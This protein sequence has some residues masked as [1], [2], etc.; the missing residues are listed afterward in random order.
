MSL[1]QEIY[2]EYS[3]EELPA[4]LDSLSPEELAEMERILVADEQDEIVKRCSE[5]VVAHDRGPMYFLRE[6]TKT[7]NFHYDKQG[8]PPKAPFPYK[9]HGVDFPHKTSGQPDWY[10][11]RAIEHKEWDYLD[12]VMNGLLGSYDL[13]KPIYIP[14]SREMLTSWL[15]VGYIFWMCQFFH[16]VEV[17][18]QSEKDDKAKGLITYANCLYTN[19]PDWMKKRFPLVR[20]DEGTQHEIAWKHTSRFLATPQGERQS[21]SYHPTIWFN[22][23]SAHQAAWKSAVNIVKPV[24]KQ[25]ICISSAAFSDFGHACESPG[26]ANEIALGL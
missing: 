1:I 11:L 8:L 25:V 21:A 14:K 12:H 23:E 16:N 3:P 19:Q 10:G 15:V 17:I 26:V 13:G 6:I 9:P 20:G 4:I 22:D 24:A 18:A 7:D 5:R 2:K